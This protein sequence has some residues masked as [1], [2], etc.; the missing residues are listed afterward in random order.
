MTAALEAAGLLATFAAMTLIGRPIAKLPDAARQTFLALLGLLAFIHAANLGEAQ[1]LAW[2]DVAGDL[3]AGAVPLLWGLFLL[4]VSRAHLNERNTAVHQ[5][6]QFFFEQVPVEMSTLDEAGRVDCPSAAFRAQFPKAAPGVPLLAGV[7]LELPNLAQALQQKRSAGLELS[8]EDTTPGASPRSF[9]WV[10]RSWRHPDH[11]GLGAL[12]MLKEI[13]GELAAAA[14]ERLAQEELARSQRMAA[15][16]QLAAGAAHDFNNLL[17]IIQS[18]V[19]ELEEEPT[20][21]EL[22][23]VVRRALDDASVMTRAMLSF[24]RPSPHA[25]ETYDLGVVLSQA[26]E[27]LTRALGRRFVLGLEAEPGPCK[28]RGNATRFQ[29]ALLNLVV[30]ARDAMPNGGTIQLSLRRV[31]DQAV[32]QVQDHGGG[33]SPEVE[34]RLFTPFFTTK[35]S[36][37][38]GLGLSVV[39]AAVEEH[40]G[41][42][43]VH[44]SPGAGTTFRLSLPLC[45]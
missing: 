38:T 33:L 37:G 31:G 24:A 10:L 44:S 19:V 9:R 15:L 2:A 25:Q 11:H 5:A 6:L 7:A 26:H 28:V 23:G 21:A 20:S 8:G 12:V 40:Q 4:E 42:V 18:A 45:K 36:Q 14:A 13:T 41:A 16:G 3:F 39:K 17:Q 32:V 27:L 35:G 34:A 22:R 1:G 29:Q 43:E 30:N